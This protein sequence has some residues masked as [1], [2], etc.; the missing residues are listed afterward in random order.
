MLR[1]KNDPTKN[2]G[3]HISSKTCE[4]IMAY[5][6]NSMHN[7]MLINNRRYLFVYVIRPSLVA[8]GFGIGRDKMVEHKLHDEYNYV[9]FVSIAIPTIY[10]KLKLWCGQANPP[11]HCPPLIIYIS[12]IGH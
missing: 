2:Q 4:G 11:L 9:G 12:W 6:N 10:M 7:P 8:N 3:Q 5:N 1:C